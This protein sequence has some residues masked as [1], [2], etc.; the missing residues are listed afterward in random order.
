MDEHSP[1]LNI[2]P[3]E[4]DKITLP[5]ALYQL[6]NN[7]LLEP[8]AS[9]KLKPQIGLSP[10]RTIQE[11][12]HFPKLNLLKSNKIHINI[13]NQLARFRLF[14]TKPYPSKIK[15]TNNIATL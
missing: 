6:D 8:T 10:Q 1:L 7:A 11:L 13:L 15:R 9:K 14:G 3:L 4:N 2:Y 5:F 12:I